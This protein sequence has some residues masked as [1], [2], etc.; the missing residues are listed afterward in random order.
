M[1]LD[2]KPVRTDSRA[3][4]KRFSLHD[5]KNLCMSLFQQIPVSQIMEYKKM[6]KEKDYLLEPVFFFF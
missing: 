5:I 3:Y 4:L 2:F 1:K 6:I